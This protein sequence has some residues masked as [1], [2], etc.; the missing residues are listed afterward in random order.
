M[1][2]QACQ[3]GVM[4]QP[5]DIDKLLRELEAMN[6]GGTGSPGDRE[7]AV[8]SS[9]TTPAKPGKAGAGPAPR[10]SRGGRLAWTGASAVG[11]LATG[12]VVG[13]V[14]AFLP[15]VST[16]S[17]AVGAALGGAVV[18]LVSGPPRWF[19]DGQ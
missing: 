18:G 4:S 7:V 14:L 19:D 1:G 3:H 2:A 9:P 5:E 12:G 15:W 8:P 17:T 16:L 11:G 6:Q 13:T 10:A